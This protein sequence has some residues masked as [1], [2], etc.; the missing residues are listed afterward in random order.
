M[1]ILPAGPA[2]RA[3]TQ[4][5]GI[6]FMRFFAAVMVM[7]F[8]LVYL[9]SARH[10]TAYWMSAGQID[11]ES[12]WPYT[13]GG[14]IG[15]QI[16]FVISGFVIALSAQGTTPRR[17]LASRAARLGP[18]VWICAPLTFLLAA[19]LM[20]EYR[21]DGLLRSLLFVPFGPWVEVVYWT[22]GIEICFY[23]LVL[24]LIVFRRA[25][26]LDVLAIVLGLASTLFWVLYFDLGPRNNAL[27]GFAR[28]RWSELLLIQHGCQFAIG[29]LLW[30]NL[31]AIPREIRIRNYA[32]MAI[33]AVGSCLQ[34]FQHH[35][36][37]IALVDTVFGVTLPMTIWLLAVLFILWS[38]A[39]VQAPP[40]DRWYRKLFRQMGL[41]T[42]PLYLLHLSLGAYAMGF[43]AQRGLSSARA[44]GVSML[45]VLAVS[46]VIAVFIEPPLQKIT[47]SALL[48]AGKASASSLPPAATPHRR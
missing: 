23:A 41:V 34:I 17:F 8:H 31:T 33:F 14:W 20:H 1:S 2:A 4:Y 6:D 26:W 7:L 24:V 30:H 29:I 10:G 3:S 12:A 19:G 16:F 44:A 22:L 13:H 37:E 21:T 32:F 25:K 9:T 27:E 47:K 15:V 39:L 28:T 46:W 40:E 11:L 5:L 48:K 45:L 43:L 18:A 36:R 35:L 42:Y 38:T